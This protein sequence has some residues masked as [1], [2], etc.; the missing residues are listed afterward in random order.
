MREVLEDLKQ[1][2]E[3]APTMVEQILDWEYAHRGLFVT[4]QPSLR[5]SPMMCRT[6]CLKR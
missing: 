3:R 1:Q 6:V 5:L 4:F 2:I